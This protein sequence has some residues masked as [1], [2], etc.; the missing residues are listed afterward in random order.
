MN[1]RQAYPFEFGTANALSGVASKLIPGIY[2]ISI[3]SLAP[4]WKG[5][6]P[7]EIG[8][9]FWRS[10]SSPRLIDTSPPSCAA[11]PSPG[12]TGLPGAEIDGMTGELY[13]CVMNDNDNLEVMYRN[14]VNLSSK[15]LKGG[16]KPMVL[17]DT[18]RE[19]DQNVKK[20]QVIGFES[21]AKKSKFI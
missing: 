21:F 5:A 7:S 2:Y 11:P 18:R 1:T 14:R 6:A 9:G 20:K 12:G 19:N 4:L 16:G 17:G 15:T 13:D 8:C 10:L 3:G